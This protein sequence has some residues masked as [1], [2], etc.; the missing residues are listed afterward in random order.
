[1]K[2]PS[3]QVTTDL[4]LGL[5]QCLLASFRVLDLATVYRLAFHRVLTQEQCQNQGQACQPRFHHPCR[6]NRTRPRVEYG[7]T[8]GDVLSGSNTV[9]QRMTTDKYSSTP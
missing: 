9:S 8:K 3:P 1:M 5:R 6:R 4:Y 2:C 7:M